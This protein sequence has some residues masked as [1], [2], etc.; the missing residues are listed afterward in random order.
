MNY[1]SLTWHNLWFSCPRPRQNMVKNGLKLIRADVWRASSLFKLLICGTQCGKTKVMCGVKVHGTRKK[2]RYAFF[3][4][5]IKSKK[6]DILYVLVTVVQQKADCVPDHVKMDA[7]PL[8]HGR[9]A[10]C[11]RHTCLKTGCHNR[12]CSRDCHLT[13]CTCGHTRTPCSCHNQSGRPL[14][15]SVNLKHRKEA[16][17]SAT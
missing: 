12:G 8:R 16:L 7:L 6:D 5:F 13:G 4:L 3:F 15:C 17:G 10:L 14:W 11:T 9:S 2:R 1:A